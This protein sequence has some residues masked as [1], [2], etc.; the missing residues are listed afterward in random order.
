MS[1]G[2]VMINSLSKLINK[3]EKDIIYEFIKYSK[4][5]I[6]VDVGAAKGFYTKRISSASKNI[7][8]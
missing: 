1:K 7:C 6:C 4:L 5:K 8:I 3:M 2:I